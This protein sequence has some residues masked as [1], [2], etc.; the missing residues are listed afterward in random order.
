M[1]RD[2]CIKC[3]VK[4]APSNVKIHLRTCKLCLHKKRVATFQS[5]DYIDNTF[6]YAWSKDLY[7]RLITFLE[8]HEM[9]IG[10]KYSMLPKATLLFQA[11]ENLFDSPEAISQE[12]VVNQ[13]AQ[14]KDKHDSGA[15]SF[16][17]FFVEEHIFSK[18]DRNVE[19]IKALLSWLETYPQH[20]I[21]AIEVFINERVALRERQI[22][23]QA[24]NPLT[25]KTIV[26][27]IE[28][29]TRLMRWLIAHMPDLT[30]WDMVQEEHVNDFLLT[31][32]PNNREKVRQR[33]FVFF[34]LAREKRL[35]MHVPIVDHP[36]RKIPSTVE[37]LNLEKQKE[38]AKQIHENIYTYPEEAF[39]T[40]LCF[41]HGLSPHQIRHI[42]TN[43]ID[44]QRGIIYVEG[45]PPVYL[46]AE[47][48]LLLEQFL[49]SRKNRPLANHRSYL[50]ISNTKRLD[51]KPVSEKYV[52][53]K[54]PAFAK[55]TP[56][57]LRMNCFTALSAL[58]GPQYL[59]YA[60]GLSINGASRYGKMEEYLLEE[61]VK[62]Q[63]E[64]FLE[65]SHQLEQSEIHYATQSSR[66]KEGVE[67][68]NTHS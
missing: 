41:Y 17:A 67:Y 21:R 39:L 68:G 58:Y 6:T 36:S 31:L 3:G 48:F 13:V 7:R 64:E 5:D 59:I 28:N 24:K 19:R 22:K 38:L 50:F 47:D 9:S 1:N 42:K 63:L 34:S 65:L 26:R 62:Q 40:A 54:V 2:R 23:L 44:I 14:W 25:V 66:N 52:S 33:L 32:K 15:P 16:R 29:I 56:G 46:L 51:D 49:K 30:G 55:Y 8:R 43:D 45:R 27:D 4:L 11:A 12:W 35:I 53:L 20:Y 37:L 10:T 57:C 61:E 60:F 18:L